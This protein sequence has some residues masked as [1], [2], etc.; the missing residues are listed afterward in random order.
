M[1]V[2]QHLNNE[3][4][5]T[6]IELLATLVITVMIGMIAYSILFNG[7]KTYERVKVEADLR[8][9]ADLIMAELLSDLF[10]LKE[11]EIANTYFPQSNSSN[12]FIQLTNGD[13]IGF[14]DGKVLL[15][16]RSEHIIQNDLIR[17]ADHSKIIEVENGQYRI[18]LTLMWTETNQTLTTESEI[19]II[20]DKE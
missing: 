19:G 8:D 1:S 14:V 11:S 2:M 17:L 3:R 4:G 20:I 7:F 9:E 10:I 18:L 15:N 16:K 13:K 5:L 12:F 6:L